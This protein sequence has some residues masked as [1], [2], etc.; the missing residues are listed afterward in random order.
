MSKRTDANSIAVLILITLVAS[1]C[2]RSWYRQRADRDAACL[3]QSR[4]DDPLWD[5]PRRT[6]EPD[7]RSRMSIVT[8]PDC[9]GRPRDDPSAERWMHR[10]Y[11]FRNRYWQQIPINELDENPVWLDHLPRNEQ[12]TVLLSPE[13]AMD[14]AHL[15]SRE[16]QSRYEQ[17]Y[18]NAL[19]L[20]GNRFEF[21]TQWL[22]GVGADFVATG[23][24]TNASR[25][26][27][28][29]DR[30]GFGRQLAGGGQFATSLLNSF[31]FEFGG[32][33]FNA[34]SGSIVATFTQPL[35]RGAFRHVRL[36]SLTQAERDLLYD[37]RDYARF[38]R[39]FYFIVMSRYYTL[40]AQ[41]QSIRNLRVNLES[42]QLNL[43]EHEELFARQMVSQIQVDQV[44][45]DYQG[46]RI[47]L[48]SAEQALQNSLDDFKFL[49]GLPPWVPLELDESLLEA[50]EF[51]SAEIG[52]LDR[53]VQQLYIRLLDYLPPNS[54]TH[55]QLSE[56][57]DEYLRLHEILSKQIPNVESELEQ[58]RERLAQLRPS[59]DDD[60][61]DKQQQ[62]R[63][64]ERIEQRLD[65]L[66]K[67]LDDSATL[68]QFIAEVAGMPEE[69]AWNALLTA[70]GRKLRE[71]VNELYIAQNQIRLFLLDIE[72]I[73]VD[74]E[75]AVT[76][77][78][79][80]RLDLMNRRGILTDS[81]R[82]VEV[83]ANALRSQ[84]DINGGVVVGTDPNKP[85]AFRFDS[86][87]NVYRVGVQFDGPLNR[88][89]ERNA[90]RAAQIAYQQARRQLMATEDGIANAIRADLRALRISRLN[91][92]ITRQQYIAATRQVDEAKINLLTSREANSNLT[93]DLLTALQGLLAAKNN[94]ISNW[95]DF[96]VS[97]IRLFADLELLFLDDEGKWFNESEGL[98]QLS[99]GIESDESSVDRAFDN[100]SID[101]NDEFDG[102]MESD[103]D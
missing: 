70:V 87:A 93:R 69:E 20:S 50:F 49:L 79:N 13:L 59:N 99:R 57:L 65:E 47:S 102:L 44:F 83:A 55:E 84:L 3:I 2:S 25:L 30:I 6:V 75:L 100:S 85:N 39:E 21:D 53:R 11:G 46:G 24:G 88:F 98:R 36:E 71:Q 80:H 35:L 76:F 77:A 12:G 51:S 94:L 18:L 38:R 60:R 28:V 29:S 40:L 67:S 5:V 22:G 37:V 64:L 27:S 89:N 4:L 31:V 17:V 8:D 34:A 81:F 92:Q 86:S 63:L 26:L 91:F 62:T 101:W 68:A 78:Q 10:P 54:P 82:R 45:Q 95:V 23:D 41:L 1:G 58:W 103:L 61:F 72:G 32:T 42:L 16:Y 15:H 33:P 74:Q 14:L 66:E 7:H 19:S 96:K 90:Y 48:F 52:D 56:P 43:Q 97:K 73:E 9:G